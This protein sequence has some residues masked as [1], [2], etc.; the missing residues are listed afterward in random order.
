MILAASL[1]L[2]PLLADV[3]WLPGFGARWIWA[4]SA[5]HLLASWLCLRNAT[6]EYQ[7]CIEGHNGRT[8]WFWRGLGAFMFALF[9]NKFLDLQSLITIF[10]RQQSR[11]EGWYSSRQS[12]QWIFIQ[13]AFTLGEM[14]LLGS[15]YLLR[16]HWKKR[17]LV[18][19]SAIF[20][21]MLILCRIPSHYRLDHFLYHMP[22][23]GNYVNAGL[24]LGASL[25]VSLGAF[26]PHRSLT[27]TPV[28]RPSGTIDA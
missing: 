22:Y 15:L 14:A 18:S 11:N 7:P 8:P 9:L 26:L 20:L 2:H 12:T 24:E 17:G 19:I 28:V 23:L 6:A 13:T 25:L 5:A 4:I 10:L 1:L 21:M 3:R 16:G 27:F